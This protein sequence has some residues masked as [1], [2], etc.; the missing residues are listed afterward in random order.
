MPDG[1]LS[2]TANESTFRSFV[3]A[4]A[5]IGNR[6]NRF[7]LG[8]AF[9]PT[10]EGKLLLVA[11]LL[12]AHTNHLLAV[13]LAL[14]QFLG[15]RIFD[16]RLDR[17]TQRPRTVVGVRAL[18]DEELLGVVAELERQAL[19]FNRSRTLPSS[20]STTSLRSLPSGGGTR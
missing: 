19:S 15:Q 3:V 10:I 2:L 6:A 7:W 8:L 13:E 11:D 14:E 9:H 4:I 18:L 17:P 16:E 1:V 20:R 12:D 5:T